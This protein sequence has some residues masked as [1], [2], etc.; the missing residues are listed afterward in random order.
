[1]F[2]LEPHSAVSEAVIL[3]TLRFMR[4]RLEITPIVDPKG[5]LTLHLEALSKCPFKIN[6]RFSYYVFKYIIK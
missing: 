4:S 1:M 3:K 6:A 2:P 5:I